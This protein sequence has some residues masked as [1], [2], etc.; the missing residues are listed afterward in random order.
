MIHENETSTESVE[1]N[2]AVFCHKLTLRSRDLTASIAH[3]I[4]PLCGRLQGLTYK[5]TASSQFLSTSVIFRI[6]THGT[7][8]IQCYDSRSVP[9]LNVVA[10]AKKSTRE[11]NASIHNTSKHCAAIMANCLLLPPSL[12]QTTA[13]NKDR[14]VASL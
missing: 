6:N 3:I 12:L 1:Q 9:F 7:K 11:T 2:P 10:A 13:V 5:T 14:Q 4:S 8:L